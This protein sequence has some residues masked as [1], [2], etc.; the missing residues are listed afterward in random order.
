M[1]GLFSVKFVLVEVFKNITMIGV[2]FIVFCEWKGVAYDFA[3]VAVLWF[4]IKRI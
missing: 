1:I 2:P 4:S 3:N